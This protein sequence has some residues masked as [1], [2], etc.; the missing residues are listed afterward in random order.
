HRLGT[1]AAWLHTLKLSMFRQQ[2]LMDGTP[3]QGRFADALTFAIINMLIAILCSI[4]L[5][6]LLVMFMDLFAG[7]M[8]DALKDALYLINV[9]II[10]AA[11]W[12]T[13]ALCVH[14]LLKITGGT[15]HDLD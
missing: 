5:P 11:V 15:R 12:G 6:I 2:Q 8:N 1:L 9:I 3:A 10:I 14:V 7:N 4:G 13:Q